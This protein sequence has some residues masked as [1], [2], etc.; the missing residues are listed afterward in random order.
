M[1]DMR[2]S[3]YISELGVLALASRLRRL[4]QRLH[5]DGEL[6]Y[7][8]L[9]MNFKT[10]WFPVLHLLIDRSP[11][12]LTEIAGLMGVSHPSMIQTIDDLTTAGLIKTR[13]SDLDRRLRELSLTDKGRR[14]CHEVRPI[15]DAFR[16]AGE[17]VNTEGGND[18]LKAVSKMERALDQLSLY[19]RIMTRLE[20]REEHNRKLSHN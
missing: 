14:L 2:N 18:F 4:L 10:K 12:A 19:D 20:V 9:N 11:L 15:W 8:T 16:T 5:A 17:E 3:D 1:K 13:Q 6:V 7:Q